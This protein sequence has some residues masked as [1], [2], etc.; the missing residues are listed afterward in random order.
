M[1]YIRVHRNRRSR[2]R[3]RTQARMKKR[4]Q[5]PLG[6]R[7]PTG[8]RSRETDMKYPQDPLG[9]DWKVSWIVVSFILASQFAIACALFAMWSNGATPTREEALRAQLLVLLTLSPVMMLAVLDVATQVW[10]SRRAAGREA[11]GPAS[12][13]A[14]NAGSEDRG[15][16]APG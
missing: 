5:Q 1:G 4:T 10:T 12:G 9:I 11:S 15:G 13:P 14:E 8:I 7:G 6:R 3:S 2:R 16:D